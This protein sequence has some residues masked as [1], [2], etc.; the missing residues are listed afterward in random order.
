MV[1]WFNG[2]TKGQPI[3]NLLIKN[4]SIEGLPL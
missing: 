1:E 2:L 4:L 3:I